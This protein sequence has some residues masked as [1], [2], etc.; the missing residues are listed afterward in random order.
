MG[1][2]ATIDRDT[3]LHKF[4]T[5]VLPEYKK[6]KVNI[7]HSHAT[8]YKIEPPFGGWDSGSITYARR[9]VAENGTFTIHN[10]TQKAAFGASESEKV[11]LTDTQAMITFGTF[12]SKQ[13]TMFI[14][15]TKTFCD[16]Y[17][18]PF[19]TL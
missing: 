18:S 19:S 8:G 11:E 4:V 13:A 7:T 16:N 14:S 15:C 3:K 5:I 12:R 17:L 6:K 1:I 10:V 9:V 2:F